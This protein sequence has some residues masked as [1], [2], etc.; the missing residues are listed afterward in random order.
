MN[1]RQAL[2]L[3][4][5]DRDIPIGES[6]RAQ[7]AAHLA[8]CAACRQAQ[9]NL[10]RALAGWKDEAAT[11]RVPDAEREW[12]AVRRRI[13]GAP[14]E[15]TVRPRPGRR[16]GW[17]WLAMPAAAAL[18]ALVFLRPQIAPDDAAAARDGTT[19][20]AETVEAPGG[21]ASTMVFVDDQSGW[22]IVWATDS[23]DRSG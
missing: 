19:A 13:R 10:A 14:E 9:T 18:V 7:L 16:F 6:A 22:L 11:V 1:C 5:R 17:A 3:L 23:S 8:A 21:N 12:L 4:S 20:R 15:T 2:S